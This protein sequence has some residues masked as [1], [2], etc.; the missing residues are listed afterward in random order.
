MAAL[1]MLVITLLSTPVNGVHVAV[2]SIKESLFATADGVADMGNSSVLDRYPSTGPAG[3]VWLV[4]HYDSTCGHCRN[5]AP[6]FAN[7]SNW[8][9]S[10]KQN[11]PS[12]VL[13]FMVVS[14]VNCAEFS[15]D[16]R[17]SK[18]SDV[19]TLRLHYLAASGPQVRDVSLADEGAA[20]TDSCWGRMA[21]FKTCGWVGHVE[22]AVQ[23]A[24]AETSASTRSDQICV[25]VGR[26]LCSNKHL[27]RQKLAAEALRTPM[28]D[29]QKA[30]FRRDVSAAHR[31]DVAGALVYSLWHE[32]PMAPRGHLQS[33]TLSHFLSHV[34]TTF[35]WLK[36]RPLVASTRI[37]ST[38]DWRRAVLSCD[39]P[40]RLASGEPTSTINVTS[41]LTSLD[42]DWRGC[43]G[44]SP[45]FRGFTCGLWSMYHGLTV[46]SQEPMQALAAIQSYVRT[47]FLCQEC[48]V[49]FSK[50]HFSSSSTPAAFQLW[51]AHNQ[52][53]LRLKGEPSDDPLAPKGVFPPLA[54]CPNC[55][56]T[57]PQAVMAFLKDFYAPL[58]S[59]AMVVDSAKVRGGHAN[60][61][62]FD[63]RIPVV[64]A[65]PL[66][67]E[68]MGL[69]MPT[70]LVSVVVV[71]GL[72]GV[73]FMLGKSA[74]RSRGVHNKPPG[75][76]NR[77]GGGAPHFPGPRLRSVV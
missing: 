4:L 51:R 41:P 44:S 29:S 73:G 27:L 49:H 63:L 69:R 11:P 28:S 21:G 53:N 43:R 60:T 2:E 17:A 68:V 61:R 15:A 70:L 31:Q 32:V 72:L 50:M 47:F 19:P 71:G 75:N 22:Q 8:L 64:D 25:A 37:T 5:F 24:H 6:K 62:L 18:V 9:D 65:R 33:Q 57:N 7:F 52:V 74:D 35:P 36:C 45:Q 26:Y 58:G 46:H 20:E 67:E 38:L 54:A 23:E 1:F 12:P 14:A 34:C 56:D 16:C 66:G 30:A 3:C 10:V 48:R 13:S 59:A 39:I 55:A 40:F 42:I 77:G 76:G